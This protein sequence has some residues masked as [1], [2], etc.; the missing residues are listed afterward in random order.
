MQV[1]PIGTHL[2]IEYLTRIRTLANEE[3]DITAIALRPGVVDTDVGFLYSLISNK[4]QLIPDP[5]RRCR[6][7]FETLR[8][9]WL[10]ATT[11]G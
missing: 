4:M 7:P 10:Q 5:F 9:R 1:T 11:K 2:L 8:T 3:P 6:L